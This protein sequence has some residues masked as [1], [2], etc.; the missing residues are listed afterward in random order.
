MRVIHNVFAVLATITYGL[1]MIGLAGAHIWTTYL[2]AR[3]SGTASALLTFFTPP[4]S[5]IYWAV[6]AWSH[7][8]VFFNHFVVVYCWVAALYVLQMVFALALALTE[9]RAAT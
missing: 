2:A 6:S 3:I 8:G 4:L 9:P 5:E 1:I 7:T